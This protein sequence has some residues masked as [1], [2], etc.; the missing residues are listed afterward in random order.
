MKKYK[1]LKRMYYNIFKA[2]R[3]Y[4]ISYG[5]KFPPKNFYSFRFLKRKAFDI[6]DNSF[7]EYII[8]LI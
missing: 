1:E 2:E 4:L 5:V 6:K 7:D 3:Y 8:D